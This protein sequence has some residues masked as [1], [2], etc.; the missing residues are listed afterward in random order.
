MPDQIFENPRLAEI[1]DAFDGPRDDLIP[2]ISLANELNAKSVLDIGCGTGSFSC[3]L[4]KNGF[5]VTGL[6]PAAA[7]L[8]IAKEKPYAD[9]VTWI[10]GDMLSLSNSQV[11]MAV[12][13]G[14]VAQVFLED[15]EWANNL[16][17]IHEALNENG[18]FVFEVRDPSKKA[19]LEWTKDNT[20]TRLDIQGIGPVEGWCEVTDISKKQITFVWTY[21]FEAEDTT[22]TSESTLCFRTREDIEESLRKANYVVEEVRDAPDRPGK[23]FVFIAK[24]I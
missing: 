4:A 7:S 15:A 8:K 17:A 10:L 14:N 18:Y 9:K 23:E 22:V 20:L 11:D 19:W 1:Y 24:R 2:Y 16:E 6:E 13:T 5:Q 21:Y 3:L 12:M